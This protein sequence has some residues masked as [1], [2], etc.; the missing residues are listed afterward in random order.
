[1]TL[2]QRRQLAVGGI[3]QRVAFVPANIE[4]ISEALRNQKAGARALA[5]KDCVGCN[6][7]AVNELADIGQRD[8]DLFARGKLDR[9]QDGLGRIVGS[10]RNLDGMDAAGIALD[11]QIGEGPTDINA[12]PIRHLN[13]LGDDKRPIIER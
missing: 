13:L 5:L 3:E 8:A 6:R 10:G 9:I 2:D 11:H 7:R 12:Q 1:M 4:Q